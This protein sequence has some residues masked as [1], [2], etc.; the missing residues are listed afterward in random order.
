MLIAKKQTM[1]GLVQWLRCPTR[2][3]YN[4][5]PKSVATATAVPHLLYRRKRQ[6]ECVV[7]CCIVESVSTSVIFAQDLPLRGSANL[8]LK[9]WFGHSYWT[10]IPKRFLALAT[11]GL[12]YSSSDFF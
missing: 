12:L 1:V 10:C 4:G 5:W 2:Q 9:G 7:S 3:K 8:S 6:H 11:I